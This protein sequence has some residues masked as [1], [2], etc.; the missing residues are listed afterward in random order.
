VSVYEDFGYHGW[1][2][3]PQYKVWRGIVREAVIEIGDPRLL[4]ILESRRT[5][6]TLATIR[7]THPETYRHMQAIYALLFPH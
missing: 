5:R 4:E 3:T 6:E 7:L 1:T 2:Q